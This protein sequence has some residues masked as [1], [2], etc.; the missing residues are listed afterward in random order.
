MMRFVKRFLTA[1]VFKT[2]ACLIKDNCTWVRVLFHAEQ[3]LWIAVRLFETC[4]NA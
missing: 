3:K 4:Q 2:F 1:G